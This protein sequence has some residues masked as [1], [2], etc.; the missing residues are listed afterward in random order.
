LVPDGSTHDEPTGEPWLTVHALSQ[1]AFCPRA[2]L[3]TVETR[4]DDPDAQKL[5]NLDFSLPYTLQEPLAC[6]C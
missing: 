4:A 6:S 3:L 5:A 1:F 2:G